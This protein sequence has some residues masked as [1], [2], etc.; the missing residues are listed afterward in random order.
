MRVRLT[1]PE[2]ICQMIKASELSSCIFF[3]ADMFAI[4]DYGSGATEHWGI[5]TYR[6]SRL[7]Y[8]PGVSSEGNKVSIAGIIAHEAAHLVSFIASFCWQSV[9]FYG[10]ITF[11]E[12]DTPS[13][14]HGFYKAV[15]I[16]YNKISF[17][18]FCCIPL[19]M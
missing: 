8:T 7:L 6:E 10:K 13:N 14:R 18:F 17:K 12:M 16:S 1:S 9:F 5:I 2:R 11:K 4:P 3:F 19:E 15:Q